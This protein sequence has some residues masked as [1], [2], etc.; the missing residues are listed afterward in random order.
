MSNSFVLKYFDFSQA[1]EFLKDGLSVTNTNYNPNFRLK[2]E[3]N[4]LILTN[5]AKSYKDANGEIVYTTVNNHLAVYVELDSIDTD[6][7]LNEKWYIYETD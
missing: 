7:L 3:D 4:K 1:L 6:D 5:A 2:L